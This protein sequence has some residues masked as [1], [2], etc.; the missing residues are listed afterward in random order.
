M[1]IRLKNA[2]LK[3]L[4]DYF[5]ANGKVMSE[6]EYMKA[7]D[8]PL[9]MQ[10][11]KDMFRNWNCM[12]VE[13]SNAY[14]DKIARLDSSKEVSSSPADKMAKAAKTVLKRKNEETV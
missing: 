2:T 10:Q 11:V 8:A 5:E 4:I 1:R 6:K 13:L 9:R 12:M 3:R 7:S 14:G